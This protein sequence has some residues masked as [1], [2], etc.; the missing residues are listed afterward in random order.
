VVARHGDAPQDVVV[1]RTDGTGLRKLTDDPEADRN[2]TWS[3]DGKTITFTS[4]R[5]GSF[6]IWAIKADG[7][8]LRQLTDADITM[9]GPPI[10]SPEGSRIAV[11][12]PARPQMPARVLVLD[13][14]KPWAAQ[15]PEVIPFSLPHAVGFSPHSW[16]ADG[17]Q[18]ALTAFGPDPSA[19]IY[20][21]G[22]ESHQVRKVSQLGEPESVAR[23]LNDNR[24]LLASY[25]GRLYLIDSVAVTIREVMSVWPDAIVGYSL[26][27]DDRLIVYG[28]RSR[29]ADI[30]LASAESLPTE[31]QR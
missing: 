1:L 22:F 10:W 29:R 17:R 9:R 8:G 6:Q 4:D 3:P 28:L 16:S 14:R 25:E 12:T 20:I 26:S 18:L 30:W 19:G 27:R 7:S 2:P 5:S 24:R 23:W 11:P 13:V 15:T 21:Y 31:R